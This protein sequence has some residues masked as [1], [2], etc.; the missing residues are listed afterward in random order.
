MNTGNHGRKSTAAAAFAAMSARRARGRVTS[1]L[2]E[3]LSE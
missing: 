1:V 2:Q 3:L